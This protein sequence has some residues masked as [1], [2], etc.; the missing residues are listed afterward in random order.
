MRR[1]FCVIIGVIVAGLL[2]FVGCG[3]KFPSS[4][5]LTEFPQYEEFNYNVSSIEVSWDLND[6]TPLVFDI[7]DKET[8]DTIISMLKEIEFQK[9]GTE[10]RDGNH[11]SLTFVC[12]EGD[13]F[14][15]PLSEIK[16]GTCEQYYKYPNSN[17][18]EYIKQIGENWKS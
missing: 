6:S 12:I 5:I 3:D 4:L 14:T 7:E 16:Y 15:V 11:S 9:S 13:K 2:C 17:I 8:I 10:M 18:Y 1:K